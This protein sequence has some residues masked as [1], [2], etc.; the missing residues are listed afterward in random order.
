MKLEVRRKKHS[1]LLSSSFQLLTSRAKRGIM[2]LIRRWVSALAAAVI[3][4]ILA[5]LAGG[6]VQ[7]VPLGAQSGPGTG[8]SCETLAS[9]VLPHTTI[10]AAQSV[11][12]AA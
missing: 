11:A 7:A 2:P 12:A 4:A 10:T 6:P 9:L 5:V 1:V 8:R 3:G